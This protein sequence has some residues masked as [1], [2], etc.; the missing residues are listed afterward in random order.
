M[1][2]SSLIQHNL[3]VIDVGNTNIQFAVID[4]NGIVKRWRLSTQSERTADEYTL[5]IISNFLQQ[6]EIAKIKEVTI[7]SVVPSVVY[8]LKQFVKNIFIVF[9]RH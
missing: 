7:C 4:S 2:K 9:S 6:E 3:L 8:E 5:N 1:N